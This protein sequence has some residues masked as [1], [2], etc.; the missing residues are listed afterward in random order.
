MQKIVRLTT[1]NLPNELEKWN[2]KIFMRMVR[3]EPNLRT[4]VYLLALTYIKRV[5]S[6]MNK[7]TETPQI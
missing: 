3:F 7:E 2:R 6:L 4:L 5:T 1:S